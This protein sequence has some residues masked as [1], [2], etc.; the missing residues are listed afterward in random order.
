M[1]CIVKPNVKFCEVAQSV[2]RLAKDLGKDD[3]VIVMASGND[4]EDDDF[5]TG[6]S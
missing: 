6:I 3:C 5:R 4:E 1:R 2:D